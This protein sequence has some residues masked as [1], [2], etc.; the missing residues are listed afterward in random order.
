MK[1]IMTI[2]TIMLLFLAACSTDSGNDQNLNLPFGSGNGNSVSSSSSG[3]S[4][5]FSE[6]NPPQD[7]FIGSPVTFAFILKNYQLHDVENLRLKVRGYDRSY[8]SGLDEEYSITR[9]PKASEAIGPGIFTGLVASGVIFDGFQKEYNFNPK[10]DYCYS[11]KTT[12]RET[13]CVPSRTNQCEVE[14]NAQ[15]TQNGPLSVSVE[16]VNAVSENIQISFVLSDKGQGETRNECFNDQDSYATPYTINSIKLGALDGDCQPSGTDNYLLANKKGSFLCEFP[17]SQDGSYP[18]QL[19][20]E[21]EYLYEESIQKSYK[22]IDPT[23]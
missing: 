9:I 19:T 23:Q 8:V 10:F 3:V 4:L 6:G 22:V 14:Y 12:F 17:R 21:L 1:K 11:A 20:M 16:R 2:M 5:E 7:I 13:V 15:T 18:I